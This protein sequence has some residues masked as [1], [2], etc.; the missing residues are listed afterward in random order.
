MMLAIKALVFLYAGQSYQVLANQRIEGVYGW[1]ELWNRWD[2]LNYQKLAVQ[3]YSA[4]GDMRPTMVFYPLFPWTIRCLA[5]V[6]QDYLV[7][8][9][10]VST[11]ASI[12]AGILLYR[13]VQLDF[14]KSTASLAV[15]FLFIFPTSYFLHI[16]YTESL[17]LMLALGCVFAARTGDWLV[18]GLLGALAC[19]TRANGL[20]LV[21]ALLVEADQQYRT[22]RRWNWQWLFAAVVPL[23]FGGYLLVNYQ[24]A[25]D[26]FAFLPIRKE[27]YHISLAPPWIGVSE[28]I[29]SLSRSP[30]QA[31][32]VGVQECLFI[33]L[34]F[35]C[36]I[37]SWIKLRPIY[38]VWMTGNWLLFI[39][40]SFVASVPRY[41]L[42]MFPIFLLFGMVARR[43]LW[44]IIITVWS[45]MY[46]ALFASLFAWGRW[47]F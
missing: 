37:L 34:G 13:L 40:V 22:T 28:A 4:V 39:S 14:N 10:L 36:T 25:G 3:G 21:P 33:A 43:R 2:A 29:A 23:G 31:Q 16:G 27:F 12:A 30:A 42:T 20:V 19:L 41:T 17:F 1:L 47:A 38:S 35:L 26:P 5:V 24:T 44:L 8:A 18:A 32:I 6:V 15:W 11:L 46:L 9:F 45:I 7:S